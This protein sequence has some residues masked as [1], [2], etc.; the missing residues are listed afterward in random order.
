MERP[1]ADRPPRWD[2]IREVEA[3]PVGILPPGLLPGAASRVVRLPEPVADKQ[4]RRHGPGRRGRRPRR[5]EV[6]IGW[7]EDVQRMLESISPVPVPGY[8]DRWQFDDMTG[9]RRLVIGLDHEG[10]PV[11][12]SLH[13]RRFGKRPGRAGHPARP[14]AVPPPRP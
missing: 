3:Y 8:E 10:R 1:R 12:I 4:W 9:G 14:G 5:A 13:P 7:Y 6:P 2:S 11:V